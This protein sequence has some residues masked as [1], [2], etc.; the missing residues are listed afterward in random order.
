MKFQNRLSAIAA[1]VFVMGSAVLVQKTAAQSTNPPWRNL[2]LDQLSGVHW[3]WIYGTQ[4]SKS[5]VF[6]DTGFNAFNNQPYFTAQ[7][8]VDS[9]CSWAARSPLPSQ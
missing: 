4:V 7:A 9:C 5:A 6:D 2:S 8:A 1:I 3:Q